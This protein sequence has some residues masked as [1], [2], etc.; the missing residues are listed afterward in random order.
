[1]AKATKEQLSQD[2]LTAT[3]DAGYSNDKQFKTCEDQNITAYV[4]VARS[5]NSC[6]KEQAF[7]NRTGFAYDAITRSI[8]MPRRKMADL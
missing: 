2:E 4:P 6:V 3:A 1:M 7:F 8:S 5:L